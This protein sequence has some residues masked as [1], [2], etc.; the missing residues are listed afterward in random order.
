MI[1]NKSISPEELNLKQGSIFCKLDGKVISISKRTVLLQANNREG[2]IQFIKDSD[3]KLKFFY[4]SL[5][6]NEIKFEYDTALLDSSKSYIYAFTWDITKKEFTV[7]LNGKE[8]EKFPM[9][10]KK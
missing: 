8:I 1:D 4:S 9:S 5:F 7:Y 2:K 3:N 6:S 10:L